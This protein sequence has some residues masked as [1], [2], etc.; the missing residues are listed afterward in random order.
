MEAKPLQHEY[1][2]GMLDCAH[3][4]ASHIYPPTPSP[5]KARV[6]MGPSLT[7]C[8]RETW[9]GPPGNTPSPSKCTG[10]PLAG[11]MHPRV[12][13]GCRDT[14]SRWSGEHPPISAIWGGP[15]NHVDILGWLS[16]FTLEETGHVPTT[17]LPSGIQRYRGNWKHQTQSWPS[18]AI[19]Q[20]ARLSPTSHIPQPGCMPVAPQ[21]QL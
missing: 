21:H 14:A 6:R 18:S 12:W 16:A 11:N 2:R 3:D 7:R 19:H 20:E 9:P 5:V 4:P 8:G 13:G 10:T 17:F 15:R 1:G